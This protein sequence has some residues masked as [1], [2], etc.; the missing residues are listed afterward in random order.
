MYST[1]N[2]L[3]D[4]VMESKRNTYLDFLRFI[5][6]TA[7]VIAHINGPDLLQQIRCFDVPLML[8]VSGL[9]FSGKRISNFWFFCKHRI[10]RLVIPV[11]LFLTF[12][13]LI[14]WMLFIVGVIPEPFS[15]LRMF[16]SYLLLYYGSIGYVWVIKVFLLIMLVTPAL[17]KIGECGKVSF[18]LFIF[19]M[20][21]GLEFAAQVLSLIINKY[22]VGYY[23]LFETIPFLLAYSVPFLI[24][25]KVRYSGKSSVWLL[26]FIAL[27]L[28]SFLVLYKQTGH[29]MPI[30]PVYKYPPRPIFILYGTTASLLLWYCNRFLREFAN[31]KFFSFVGS[32][33][34]WIYLWH[35]PFVNFVNDNLNN[36]LARFVVVYLGAIIVFSIQYYLVM[37]LSSNKDSFWRKYLVG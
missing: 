9:A 35:I 10:K 18:C 7:I 30:S 26:I 34:I 14:N 20:L 13:F 31:I 21:M 29:C 6:L 27:T 22:A 36:A 24:G 25:T 17:L 5:G 4:Y 3:T 37:H 33:T 32:N 23:V 19:L 12:Y 1:I 11:Y 28:F 8:F 16:C 2:S 15:F